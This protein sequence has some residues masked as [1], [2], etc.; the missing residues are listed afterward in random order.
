MQKI[1]FICLGNI[2]RSPMAEYIFRDQAS[3]HGLAVE[4]ASAG[5]SGWHNGEFMHCGTADI[6]DGMGID[7]HSF[8]SS[9]VPKNAMQIYDYLIVMDNN[10]LRDMEKQFGRQPEKLFK[11]TDLLPEHSAY[12]HVPDPWY[13]GNFVETRDILT[14]C[15]TILVERL[16]RKNI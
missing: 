6:L 16:L 7:T 14:E 12:D 9:Q 13:T 3:K 8:V 10:N 5:T 11:I 1:L 2:C 4:V 15:C